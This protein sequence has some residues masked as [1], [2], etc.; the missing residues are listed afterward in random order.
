MALRCSPKGISTMPINF[1]I[2]ALVPVGLIVESVTQLDDTILGGPIGIRRLQEPQRLFR[3][4]EVVLGREL[5]EIIPQADHLGR[6]ARRQNPDFG[7]LQRFAIRLRTCEHVAGMNHYCIVLQG[8]E[9]NFTSL[10][11][12][13]PL[14]HLRPPKPAKC[15]SAPSS[16]KCR[17]YCPYG[18]R[19]QRPTVGVVPHFAPSGAPPLG[20]N[21]DT[22]VSSGSQ[23][24]DP[25][26]WTAPSLM[27]AA[28]LLSPLSP[29]SPFSPFSPGAP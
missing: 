21:T 2:S 3:L 22:N 13:D 27:V 8:T 15:Y 19:R 23:V 17:R 9:T 5:V 25:S 26:L 4:L 7:E 20:Q 14:C 10:L 29:L 11:E 24:T 1:R 28:S 18:F 12:A 16:A 6:L